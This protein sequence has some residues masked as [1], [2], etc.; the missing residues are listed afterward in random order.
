MNA[1]VS[2]RPVIKEFMRIGGRK[3]D[4][5]GAVPVHYPYTNEVIGT[6]PA[7]RAEHAAQAF[8]IARNYRPKLTRYERQQI[9][10][11]TAELIRSRKDQL[12]AFPRKTR[13]MR[14]AALMTSIRS[15]ASFAFS[16][17]GK[18]SPA[19]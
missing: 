4:A 15:Q 7:G 14:W 10:F 19:I 3:V 16:T 9:L 2:S 6:V 11:R 18:S 8:A 17:T 13:S 12:S 5:E 1:P